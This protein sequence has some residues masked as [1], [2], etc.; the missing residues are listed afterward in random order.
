M[1]NRAPT[2]N[3]VDSEPTTRNTTEARQ[4]GSAPTNTNPTPEQQTEKTTMPELELPGET[5]KEASATL[6]SAEVPIC[7]T[8]PELLRKCPHRMVHPHI[9]TSNDK[10]PRTSSE[11]WK[12]IKEPIAL[13]FVSHH[14]VI[15]APF[16]VSLNF[17]NRGFDEQGPVPRECHVLSMG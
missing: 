12:K 3:E 7:P 9:K 10:H 6:H 5:Q 17:C 2:T 14:F 13:F 15:L 16:F 1:P 8:P 4:E 11:Y